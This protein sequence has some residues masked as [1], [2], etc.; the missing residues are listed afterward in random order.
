MSEVHLL[1]GEPRSWLRI[2]PTVRKP[3]YIH[4]QTSIRHEH[5][6]KQ[7]ICDKLRI[8][9]DKSVFLLMNLQHVLRSQTIFFLYFLHW[10]PNQFSGGLRPNSGYS[11]YQV[12]QFNA[13]TQEYAAS[14]VLECQDNL[15]TLAVLKNHYGHTQQYSGAS[16]A[17]PRCTQGAMQYWRFKR[18]PRMQNKLL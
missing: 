13:R 16:R 17:I 10:P 8:L 4:L 6:Q 18:V 3:G 15:F 11:V 12:I 14:W 1:R 9:S 7:G 5:K 2:F